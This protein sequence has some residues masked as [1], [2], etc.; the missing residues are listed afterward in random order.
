MEK[1][2]LSALEEKLI[3]PV[4]N[5]PKCDGTLEGTIWPLGFEPEN[6]DAGYKVMFIWANCRGVW[7]N[8][9]EQVKD[10]TK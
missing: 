5:C 3:P 9:A 1:S 7:K 10:G 4:L 2:N 6:G 8:P